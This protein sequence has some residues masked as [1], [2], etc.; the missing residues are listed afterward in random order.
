MGTHGWL[1]L[2]L[3]FLG[4]RAAWGNALP[5]NMYRAFHCFHTLFNVCE[6]C[7]RR[8]SMTLLAIAMGLS[9]AGF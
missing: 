3:D 6:E 8:S 4:H 1:A 9:A 5:N 7:T 2:R